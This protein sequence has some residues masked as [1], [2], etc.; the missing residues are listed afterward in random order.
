MAVCKIQSIIAAISKK[1]VLH[2]LKAVV[3]GADSFTTIM[4]E[5]PGINSRILSSRLA[6][7]EQHQLIERRIISEKPV[8]IRYYPTAYARELSAEFDRM[9]SIVRSWN[10]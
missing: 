2:I 1:W 8:K 4:K 3:S 7:M 6:E 9:E 5:V 10:L